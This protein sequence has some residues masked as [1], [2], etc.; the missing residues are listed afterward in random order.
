MKIYISI[1]ME[2]ISGTT[3]WEDVEPG[4]A[5]YKDS[6]LQMNRELKAAIKG[7]KK[8]GATEILIR[9]AHCHGDN[10]DLNVLESGCKLIRGWCGDP[11]SMVQGIDS[12]FDGV[13]FIGYHSPA[14]SEGSP[15]SHTESRAPFKVNLNDKLTGEF[16]LYSYACVKENVKVLFLSGDKMLCENAKLEYKD[17]YTCI[18]KEG[19]GNSSIHNN[20]IDVANEIEEKVEK[21]IKNINNIKNPELDETFKLEVVYKEHNRAKRHSFFPGVEQIDS[22]T[23]RF[24]SNEYYEILRTFQYIFD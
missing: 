8:A 24:Q 21:A 15:L 19:K 22:N 9:D 13:I 2:G 3:K 6:V 7:A 18:T 20:P 14:S 16:D 12:S 17:I 23:L 4:S 1:D 5:E 10:L 11:Y